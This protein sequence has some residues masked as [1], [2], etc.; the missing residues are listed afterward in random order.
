MTMQIQIML[1]IRI[2]ILYNFSL[3]TIA[4]Y[5]YVCE[6]VVILLKHLFEY[7]K[8][9]TLLPMYT[10]NKEQTKTTKKKHSNKQ[11]QT[12]TITKQK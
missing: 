12:K 7:K 10:L 9:Y 5:I 6:N 8:A 3:V 1:S 11:K 4:L 2:A